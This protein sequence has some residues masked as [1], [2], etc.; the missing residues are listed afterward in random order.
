MRFVWNLDT[1]TESAAGGSAALFHTLVFIWDI[2]KVS[3]DQSNQF[4]VEDPPN[5]A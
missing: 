3:A 2:L 4:M 1:D 5:I